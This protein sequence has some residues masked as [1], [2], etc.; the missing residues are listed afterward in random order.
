MDALTNQVKN[1]YEQYP[2]P[3]KDAGIPRLAELYNLLQLFARETG[4]DFKGK[5][6]LDAGTGT[7]HRL[8]EAARSMPDTSFVAIDITEA[9]LQTARSL[10]A[11]R[12]LTNVGFHHRDILTDTSDLGQFDV[13]MCMGVLHHL[14]NPEEGLKNLTARLKDK[15]LLFLYLYGEVGGRERMRRKTIVSLLNNGSGNFEQGLQLIKDLKFDTF[16]YGWNLP[17]DDA[18]LRDG[19]LV[20]AYLHVNEKLYTSESIINLLNGSGLQKA[21][22]YGITTGQ[23]GY[24]YDTTQN[25]TCSLRVPKTE[26]ASWLSSDL[27]KAQFEKLELQERMQLMDLWFEP[28]GYTVVAWQNNLVDELA[29]GDRLTR[30]GFMVE[31]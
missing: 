8:V 10:A 9:S 19:L 31:R 25:G 11:S 29:G 6:I 27:L 23:C 14:A 4:F 2:Y 5:R 15:G 26:A 20:D 18:Q 12:G 24:L 16:E 13:V 3:S 7:G 22:L 17:V 1:M 21:A 30:N 28:N